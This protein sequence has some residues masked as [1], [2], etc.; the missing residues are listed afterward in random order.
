[1]KLFLTNVNRYT[2]DRSRI[3]DPEALMVS[4]SKIG[5][6]FIKLLESCRDLLSD[7]IQRRKHLSCQFLFVRQASI[8]KAISINSLLLSRSLWR[9]LDVQ[10]IA[11][12]FFAY[13]NP[14]ST[15]LSLFFSKKDSSARIFAAQLWTLKPF[16]CKYS[17]ASL[18]S[19]STP[20]QTRYSTKMRTTALQWA[21]RRRRFVLRRFLLHLSK[22]VPILVGF[23]G[24]GS[25]STLNC[26]VS[27]T[28]ASFN[29]ALYTLEALASTDPPTVCNGAVGVSATPPPQDYTASTSVFTI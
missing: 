18:I 9:R 4:R 16:V 14:S 24:S 7:L 2:P 8:C 10:L 5:Y 1:L 20:L 28:P 15:R 25:S 3:Q 13:L 17:C 27:R 11:K 21:I 22:A 23:W 6:P 26:I 12:N 29:Q 19:P